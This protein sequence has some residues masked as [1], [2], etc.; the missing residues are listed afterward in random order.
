MNKTIIWND[1]IN[2]P[3]EG[4][5]DVS[6]D[7]GT[8]DAQVD[9]S[10]GVNEGLDMHGKVTISLDD[11]EGKSIEIPVKQEGKREAFST[12]DGKVFYAADGGSF[13]V[14]KPGLSES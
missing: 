2:S 1:D 12:G 9:F 6:V 3:F 5:V 10:D 11:F 14:L 8:G 4:A 7:K 13:N